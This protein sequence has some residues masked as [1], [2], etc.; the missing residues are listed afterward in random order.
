MEMGHV[1]KCCNVTS[2]LSSEGFEKSRAI[3][4]LQL[5]EEFGNARLPMAPTLP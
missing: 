3:L 2:L 5:N 4:R 1:H